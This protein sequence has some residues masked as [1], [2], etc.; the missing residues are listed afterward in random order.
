MSRH[1]FDWHLGHTLRGYEEAPTDH[2]SQPSG[3]HGDGDLPESMTVRRVRMWH[4]A[5]Y[6]HEPEQ[7]GVNWSEPGAVDVADGATEVTGKLARFREVEFRPMMV[8]G[9]PTT[10]IST[11]EPTSGGTGTSGPTKF[12]GDAVCENGEYRPT[13]G[14]PIPYP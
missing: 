12:Y 4:Y 7:P 11:V 6:C 9:Q 14:D 5:R 2:R 3:H 1:A 8:D 10:D 13:Y